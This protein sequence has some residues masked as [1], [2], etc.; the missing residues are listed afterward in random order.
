[1]NHE[2]NNPKK[3]IKSEVLPAFLPTTST[4]EQLFEDLKLKGIEGSFHS[5]K[6][7]RIW[8][9]DSLRQQSFRFIE[10]HEKK[11]TMDDRK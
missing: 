7:E 9:I 10:D 4:F 11:M 5:Q 6:T 8:K 1:M 2:Q 3:Q